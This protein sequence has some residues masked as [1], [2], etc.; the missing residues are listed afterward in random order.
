MFCSC[1]QHFGTMAHGLQYRDSGYTRGLIVARTRK[2]HSV[3]SPT[4]SLIL[5]GGSKSAKFCLDFQHKSHVNLKRNL[6][7]MKSIIDGGRPPPIFSLYITTTQPQI[8]RFHRHLVQFD[9]VTA[10]TLWCSL[11]K[12]QRSIILVPERKSGSPNLKE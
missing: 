4:P 12:G 10:D 8:V 1:P 11:S 3:I 6:H 2:I 5:Q 9:H 7:T